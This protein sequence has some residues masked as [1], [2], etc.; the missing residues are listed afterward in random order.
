MRRHPAKTPLLPICFLA[1]GLSASGP[2]SAQPERI[3]VF[4]RTEGFRH[5][6][7]ADG[8]AMI[9]QL[10]AEEGYTVD[11]TEETDLFE[12]ASLALYDVVVFLS[13]TGDVLDP[14][15]QTAFEAWVESGG[16]FV[17]IHSA[18]DTEYGWP[19]YGEL[20]GG[21]A[22]FQNHPPVQTATL[23][24]EAPDHPGAGTFDTE[25]SFQDEWYNFQA[26]PRPAVDVLMTIDED[27]YDPGAGAMGPD[28]PIVWAHEL[29]A[30]RSFYTVLGHLPQTYQDGR[31]REQ[32]RGAIFWASGG[33]F[34]DGFEGGDTS[35]WTASA[36]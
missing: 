24:L 31:F 25:T 34:E 15:E 23:H 7:I 30:G 33:V 1:I 26:N 21:G 36:P 22:W 8:V 6:S 2:L 5:P 20:L 16:G 9:G 4:S 14:P 17:G 10:G 27:T 28:H 19:W 12:P 35:E 13:T 18:A 32:I 3:L 29:E 11:T